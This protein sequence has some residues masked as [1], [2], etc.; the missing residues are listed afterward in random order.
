MQR[1]NPTLGCAHRKTAASF[2]LKHLELCS[3]SRYTLGNS[4]KAVVR[5]A[6]SAVSV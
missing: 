6:S 3:I 1:E 4:G 2:S 5:G